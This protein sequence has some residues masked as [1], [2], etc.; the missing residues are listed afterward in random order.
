MGEANCEILDTKK[1]SLKENCSFFVAFLIN[2]SSPRR[3]TACAPIRPR[4][5]RVRPEPELQWHGVLLDFFIRAPP[6]TRRCAQIHGFVRCRSFQHQCVECRAADLAT[7]ARRSEMRTEELNDP[8]RSF[9]RERLNRS[10]S[11]SPSSNETHTRRRRGP[12]PAISRGVPL[13]R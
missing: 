9:S 3:K 11:R 5:E 4:K 6:H 2:L 10:G 12:S 7:R 1:G 8:L 13:R